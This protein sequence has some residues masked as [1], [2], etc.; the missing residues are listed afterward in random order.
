MP[1]VSFIAL[2]FNHSK[3]LIETL[4]SIKTQSNH[5]DFEI[6]ITDDSSKDNSVELIQDWVAQNKN[7]IKIQTLFNSEN[8][9]LC[10]TL[11]CAIGLA[12]GQW[13]KPIACD[14]ILENNY[15]E[16]I[17]KL[18]IKDDS[19]GL[20]CTDMSHINNNGIKI[21]ES[22]WTYNQT[23]ISN[24][25]VN[26][27]NNL[28]RAQYLNAPTLF[29]KREL[30]E[31]LGGYDESLIFEDW[32]FL[33]RAK[34]ITKFA[35]IKESLVRYRMHENNMHLNFKTNDRYLTD[36]I[37]LLKKQLSKENKSILKNEVINQ[38][39]S[40]LPINENKAIEVWEQEYNWLKSDKTGPLVS[41]LIPVY[42]A[43]LYIVNAIKS[44]LLQT[45]S[46]IEI[47][48]IN[49]G[50]TDCTVQKIKELISNDSRIKFYN[51]INNLGLIE[52]LNFGLNQCKGKYIARMDADDLISPNRINNQIEFLTQNPTISAVSSWMLE[53]DGSGYNKTIQY[54]NDLN[55]I[56]S[57]SMFYSPVS[58][59]ASLFHAI[60]LKKL[61]YR[62]E[63]T[64]AEDYDMWIRFLQNYK[65]GVIPE[66]LYYY[67][68]H[69]NQ[70]IK[71]GNDSKKEDSN[72]KIIELI[73]T[74]FKIES[75]DHLRRFHLKY[76]FKEEKIDSYK[77]FKEWDAYLQNLLNSNNTYLQR[78]SFCKY[79][80][81][82]YW[83]TN[84]YNLTKEVKFQNRLSIV[85]SP[86]CLLSYL[87][88]LKY[89]LLG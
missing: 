53:F 16:S 19:I 39:S 24:T 7:E 2:S 65:V 86:F 73:H 56:K 28:L 38:I 77:L 57:V 55:E 11:N 75:T 43:E 37:L 63:F 58:H 32:D 71:S 17:F 84:F 15:L 25:I 36:T 29:F 33:L 59:A 69:A 9:G 23:D 47:I 88:K 46:N 52:T 4:N 78:G 26:E 5:I 68:S 34:K 40:L 22:N 67:R 72:V 64:F 21:R 8:I 14:D 83:Q 81:K 13:I 3:F 10:K 42:N 49:D 79:V 27:F 61:E 60:V 48:V 66:V 35:A 82:N 41:I 51:N 31:K 76:L 20:V 30:W 45:Y 87:Q 54:R 85:M 50:S 62:N 89:V 44:C 70:S 74:Y 6:I 1:F 18:I 80:F 12:K